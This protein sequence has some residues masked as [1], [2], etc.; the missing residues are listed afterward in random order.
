VADG[1]PPNPGGWLTTTTNRKV[2]DRIWRENKRVAYRRSS[3]P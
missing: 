1:V 3:R 2:I